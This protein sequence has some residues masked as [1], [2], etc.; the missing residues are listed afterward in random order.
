MNH[1]ITTYGGGE[2]FYLVFNGIADL[3]K[4]DHTGLVTSL[5]RVGLTIGSVYVMVLMLFRHQLEEGLKWFLKTSFPL[6]TE[7]VRLT[8]FHGLCAVAPK[9]L[10]VITMMSN[11]LFIVVFV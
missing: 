10:M 6:A 8:C 9:K 3:F 5:I 4:T 1:V 11:T 7:E 2:L